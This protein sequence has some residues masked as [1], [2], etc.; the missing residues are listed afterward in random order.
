MPNSSETDQASKLDCPRPEYPRP[1]L[2]RDRWLNLNG[3]WDFSADP[4]GVGVSE[5]WQNR[6]EWSSTIT[7]PFAPNSSASGCAIDPNT[8]RVWYHHSFNNPGWQG[9][10]V[11][12][13]IG[14]CDFITTVFLNGHN[15]GSHTGGYS[16][17]KINITGA[18]QA[19]ENHLVIAVKDSG[20]WQQPRGKQAGDTRWPIDYDA[21][22]G[23]WQTVWLEP[24][25]ATHIEVL[26]YAFSMA[27]NRL[28]LTINLS[29]S[30][31]GEVQVTV[32]KSKMLVNAQAPDTSKADTE[33]YF[34]SQVSQQRSEIKTALHIPDPCLWS[35][36]LPQLYDVTIVLVN[37]Q[38][39]EV[40]RVASYTGLREVAV[41]AGKLCLNGEAIY[42]RGVLDQGYFPEGWYTPV[43]DAAMVRDIKLAKQLGFNLVR[44]HQK[45]E[46]P[47]Y[48]YW[49]DQLGLMVWSEMPSGRIFSNNLVESLTQEWTALV[50]RDQAH[51]CVICWVPFNESW[52]V[53]HQSSRPQQRAFVDAIYHLTKTLDQ[54]RPV[55]ANDGWEYSS[56]DL[57]TLHLY[58]SA[59]NDLSKRLTDLQNNPHATVSDDANSRVGTLPGADPTGLPILLTECGGVGFTAE[60]QQDEH[61]FYGTWPVNAQELMARIEDLGRGLSSL[62]ALQ[63][64]VWTQLTDVQQEIN[65]LLYFDR[66]PKLPVKQLQR[67]FA[68]IGEKSTD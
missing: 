59:S 51:P 34:I 62:D 15:V 40:D 2:R 23:I 12:L 53:W 25:Q 43:D 7:V 16:P 18:L 64:F 30:F 61:F 33:E 42:L 49:A 35:P 58:D 17:I 28:A 32:A 3:Q 14:A 26:N 24:V 1:I 47:R 66:Q 8:Q 68:A 63:G 55:V 21:V 48:L 44:K 60:Q 54:T 38:G 13:N 27:E 36:D 20:S 5:G 10:E 4:D 31:D 41:A 50:R 45:A 29:D 6:T 37:N 52:G 46:D 67:I 19:G 9:E 22:I 11:V 65:G 39:A 56:G 57:W